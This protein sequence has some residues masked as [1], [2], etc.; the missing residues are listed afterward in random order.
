MANEWKKIIIGH[1][2][3]L[4]ITVLFVA[5]IV[6]AWYGELVYAGV[7]LMA[8]S[9][10]N[11]FYY[12]LAH[13]IFCGLC[14]LGLL[15]LGYDSRPFAVVLLSLAGVILAANII[16]WI[17]AIKRTG[18]LGL[19]RLKMTADRPDIFDA[20]ID[21]YKENEITCIVW[22]KLKKNPIE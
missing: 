8:L 9:M 22:N 20:R 19:L 3:R 18:G 6:E 11:M 15:L 16:L 2:L 13:T 14:G 17:K 12:G 10:V 1:L 4:S 7:L 21:F 5:S